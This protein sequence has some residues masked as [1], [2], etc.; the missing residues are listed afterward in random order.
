MA[1]LQAAFRVGMGHPILPGLATI[2]KF[3][4]KHP[5]IA[6]GTLGNRIL[7]Y[8]PHQRTDD[9]KV[10][11]R[12]LNINRE[13]KALT[14]GKLDSSKDTE[15]LLVGTAT[16]IMAYDVE[17]NQDVY[18][19][20]IPDGVNSVAVG[21]IEDPSS[22]LCMVGGNCTIQGFDQE[23]RMAVGRR[24][25]LFEG[26]LHAPNFPKLIYRSLNH[27]YPLLQAV[28]QESF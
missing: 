18:F 2:G 19:K 7:V 21:H 11:V 1:A 26:N 9:A 15:F 27:P 3:D 16:H 13:L 28:F 8:S 22:T 23:V 10:D 5:A 25:A 20:E 17:R 24:V 4:G 6:A 14:S 12:F